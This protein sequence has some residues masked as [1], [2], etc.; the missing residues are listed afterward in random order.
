MPMRL[1][2]SQYSGNPLGN[3]IVNKPNIRGIIINII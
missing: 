3:I 1:D 2:P